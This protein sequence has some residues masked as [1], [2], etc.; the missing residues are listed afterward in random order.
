MA[1]SDTDPVLAGRT[2]P[3]ALCSLAIR[4]DTELDGLGNLE[5][6]LDVLSNTGDGEF[7]LGIL[8]NVGIRK[9]LGEKKKSSFYLQ[10]DGKS[11]LGLLGLDDGPIDDV[12]EDG[13]SEVFSDQ[14]EER[15]QPVLVHVL[16]PTLVCPLYDPPSSPLV[17]VILPVGHDPFLRYKVTT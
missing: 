12:V 2:G 8:A 14:H 17:L 9:E 15:L 6:F 11:E 4:V 5:G 7:I 10:P 16:L 3:E 1:R 13:G